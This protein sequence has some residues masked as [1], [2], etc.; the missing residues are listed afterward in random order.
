MAEEAGGSLVEAQQGRRRLIKAGLG[1]AAVYA[2]YLLFVF[3]N[4]RS[5]IYQGQK[6]PCSGNESYEIAGISPTRISRAI[7]EGQVSAFF[8]RSPAAS[9][10]EPSPL[11][12]FAHGNAEIVLDWTELLAWYPRAGANL[13]VLEYRGYCGNSGSPRQELIIDD[14]KFFVE[15]AKKL[16]GVDSARLIFHG[17]SLGS[18]V[19][20]LLAQRIPPAA[21]ILESTFMDIAHL[22]WRFGA[23]SCLVMDSYNI[24]EVMPQIS[25]P[26]LIL[27]GNHDEF[28]LKEG[29]QELASLSR[30]AVL[31]FHDCGHNDCHTPALQQDVREFLVARGLLQSL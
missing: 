13:L 24:A 27:H 3:A 21:I 2:L 19:L 25:C 7:Q 16:P 30:T 20:A 23:P 26:V 9:S 6:R 15:A 22:S 18:G 10:S 17:R 29:V 1:A 8:Y 11:V 28:F 12:V 4:Q 31:K 14:A 5:L